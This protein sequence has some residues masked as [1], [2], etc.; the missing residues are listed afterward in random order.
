MK[1]SALKQLHKNNQ[2]FTLVELMV[3]VAIIGIL[4]AIA[5]PQYNKFKG[6]AQLSNVQGMAKQVA[7]SAMSLGSG[8]QQNPACAADSSVAVTWASPTL[9][10]TGTTSNATCDTLN[11]W[12][13]PP[14]WVTGIVVTGLVVNTDGTIANGGV[15]TVDSSYTYAGSSLGCDYDPTQD[16]LGPSTG[17]GGVCNL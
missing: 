2:G 13:T 1:T 5:I 3:V 8:A 12:T 17:A 16:L 9:T 14:A 4:A 7:K 11:L 10:A 6:N 15:I